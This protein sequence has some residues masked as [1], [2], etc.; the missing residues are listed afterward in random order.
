MPGSPPWLCDIPINQPGHRAGDFVP[1]LRGKVASLRVV[2]QV[3]GSACT[4]DLQG[5]PGH[6]DPTGAVAPHTFPPEPAWHPHAVD[7]A[8]PLLPSELPTPSEP[9]GAQTLKE[10]IWNG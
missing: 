10:E 5:D 6:T 4:T 9:G 7:Q 3:T 8:Q 1:A 2:A